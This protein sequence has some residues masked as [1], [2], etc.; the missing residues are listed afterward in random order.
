M[1]LS[2]VRRRHCVSPLTPTFGW[3]EIPNY[4]GW[5]PGP[6]VVK[7]PTRISLLEPGVQGERLELT[8]RVLKMT[9]EPVPD[10]RLE[11]WQADAA[12]RYDM[13]GNKLRGIQQ[14]DTA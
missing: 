12:G 10:V 4:R 14:L 5:A 7:L 13:A 9:G 8:G 6:R 1:R 3:D 11:F 2:G